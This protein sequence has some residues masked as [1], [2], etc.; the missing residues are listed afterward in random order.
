MNSR[1]Q[2]RVCVVT[3]AAR[4]IGLAIA[5][6]FGQEGGRIACVDVSARRLE[7]AVEGL[8]S[9]GFDAKPYEV[10]VGKRDDVHAL[11]AR[12]ESEFA[13]PVAVLVNNAVFARFE[14][15][16]QIEVETVDRMFAVGVHGLIWT[17]QAAAPQM[18]RRGGGSIVNLSSVSAFNPAKDS[19]AY[20]ALKAGVV[21]LSRASA[22]EL[23]A[24]K[25]RV[26]VIAPGMIGTPASIAQFDEATIA[27]RQAEMPAGRFGEPEEIAALAAFLASDDA[28]YIQGAVI[29]ADGGWTIPAR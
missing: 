11:F 4:G 25:I 3:G 14:P 17:T 13:A 19:I 5:E 21:G 9:K 2:D 8:K 10:D 26:N 15:L 6:R 16:A 29:T 20:S 23:S 24:K 28:S 1:L 18:E 7:P 27:T 22:I 12:I